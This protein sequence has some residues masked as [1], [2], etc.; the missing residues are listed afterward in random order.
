MM[1]VYFYAHAIENFFFFEIR[2]HT[3]WKILKTTKCDLEFE[4]FVKFLYKSP[5]VDNA[6]FEKNLL[7][8]YIEL[9]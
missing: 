9:C 5:K 4:I 7:D 2:P 1:R 8:I 3:S 6:Y